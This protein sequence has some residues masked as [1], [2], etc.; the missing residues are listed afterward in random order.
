MFSLSLS[1]HF[2]L[3]KEEMN[4][5]V[6]NSQTTSFLLASPPC[7]FP[8]HTQDGIWHIFLFS[9][10]W[11]ISEEGV[12]RTV[13]KISLS[14]EEI[15]LKAGFFSAVS[16]TGVQAEALPGRILGPLV[17]HLF[18]RRSAQVCARCVQ[19]VAGRIDLS[20][21]HEC[22]VPS[23]LFAALFSNYFANAQQ[24]PLSFYENCV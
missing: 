19:G 18:Q 11:V 7:R 13:S 14:E 3:F 9:P 16:L 10:L 23:L 15:C 1:H 21:N 12:Y 22:H 6:T 17:P 2:E 8:R 4:S 5:L 24:F 20:W